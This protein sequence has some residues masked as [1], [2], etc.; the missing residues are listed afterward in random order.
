MGCEYIVLDQVSLG[1][2]NDE[3]ANTSIRSHIW[4]DI[5]PLSD[6]G[7][8]IRLD[9]REWPWQG[10]PFCRVL[11]SE[12]FVF[13]LPLV[14]RQLCWRYI[15][16]CDSNTSFRLSLFPHYPSTHPLSCRTMSTRTVADQDLSLPLSTLLRSG[17]AALHEQVEKSQGAGRLARGELDEPEYVHF[18]MMLWHVYE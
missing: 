11:S 9:P 17:T 15:G 1:S 12:I 5:L 14:L 18:L 10:T 3:I 6:N 2:L 7:I 4:R 13:H 8:L 16:L